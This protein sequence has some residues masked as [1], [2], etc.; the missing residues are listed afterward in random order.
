MGKETR[1]QK[2]ERRAELMAQRDKLTFETNRESERM[3]Q[4][5]QR[6]WEDLWIA[7]SSFPTDSLFIEAQHKLMASQQ[8]RANEAMIRHR[9]EVLMLNHQARKYFTPNLFDPPR[10]GMEIN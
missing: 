8:Q 6:E 4:R 3:R 10:T 7:R 9:L 5:F 1:A 2:A